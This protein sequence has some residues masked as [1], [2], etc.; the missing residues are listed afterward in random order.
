MKPAAHTR[1]GFKVPVG[2]PSTLGSKVKHEQVC[3]TSC[4]SRGK[5]PGPL[6]CSGR[7]EAEED[8]QA[9]QFFALFAQNALNPVMAVGQPVGQIHVGQVELGLWQRVGALRRQQGILG[10]LAGLGG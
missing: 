6:W 4:C 9:A 8:L 3:V 1:R 2:G 5:V 10:S 7:V